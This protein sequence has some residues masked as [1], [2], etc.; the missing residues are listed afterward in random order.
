MRCIPDGWRA[1]ASAP[2][3]AAVAAAGVAA[4]PDSAAAALLAD[5]SA[6]LD[7]TRTVLGF[8]HTARHLK[9]KGKP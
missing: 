8:R 9:H 2:G 4:A 5:S 6:D 3:Q 7:Y 1:E